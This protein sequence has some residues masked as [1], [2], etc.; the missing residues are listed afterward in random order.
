M[1]SIRHIRAVTA[2]RGALVALPLLAAGCGTTIVSSDKFVAADPA[3]WMAVQGRLPVEVHGTVPGKAQSAL[4]QAFPPYRANEYAALDGG[5]GPL[6][7]RIVLYV[8]AAALPPAA[9]LCSAPDLFRAGPQTGERARV[10]GALCQGSVVVARADGY[11][12][13]VDQSAAGLKQSF[14]VIE[15]ALFDVLQPGATD[16]G[17]YYN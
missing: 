5:V 9:A 11:A 16:P 12:L 13:S 17:R 4:A 2:L 1:I 6:A 3:A 15:D 8:N 7:N 10:S 14:S